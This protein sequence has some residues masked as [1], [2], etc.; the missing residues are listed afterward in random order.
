MCAICLATRPTVVYLLLDGHTD[1]KRYREAASPNRARHC[2]SE[3]PILLQSPM[4]GARLVPGAARSGYLARF[5]VHTV[6]VWPSENF[7]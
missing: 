2:A 1:A 5:S 6:A 3:V 7:R 4:T